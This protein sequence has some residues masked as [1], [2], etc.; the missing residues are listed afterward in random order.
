M[1]NKACSSGQLPRGMTQGRLTLIHKS[2]SRDDL[3][4][5]RP[6]TL[7]NSAYK[8]LAKALQKRIKSLLPELV[9]PDQTAFVPKRFILDN[10]LV[11]HEVIDIARRTKQKLF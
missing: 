6:I 4:N 3:N 8:I 10:V 9:S 11:A 2:G 7:L 5:W 1:V